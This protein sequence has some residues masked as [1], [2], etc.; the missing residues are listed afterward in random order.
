MFSEVFTVCNQRSLRLCSV[1]FKAF[2]TMI[3]EYWND[4]EVLKKL[5]QALGIPLNSG[6]V[7]ASESIVHDTADVGDVQ[8][9]YTQFLLE[10]GAK[11]DSLDKY[12]NTTFHHASGYDKKECQVAGSKALLTI[13]ARVKEEK[14]H[15]RFTKEF[16]LVLFLYHSLCNLGCTRFQIEEEQASFSGNL[17]KVYGA[18]SML[19]IQF[20]LCIFEFF[21]INRWPGE[22]QFWLVQGN[23]RLNYLERCKQLEAELHEGCQNSQLMG[24]FTNAFYTGAPTVNPVVFF[25]SLVY[26]IFL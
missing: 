18:L 25:P 12:K 16:V 9:K 1:F 11:V 19:L 23:L 20:S 13:L 14:P 17:N 3:V 21:N 22:R 10:S 5:G 6:V 15:V 24:S 26:F 8:V 2:H 7:A 4:E